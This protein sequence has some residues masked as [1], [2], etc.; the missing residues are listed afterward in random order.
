MQAFHKWQERHLVRRAA[1]FLS[2]GD[3]KIAS[4]TLVRCALRVNDLPLAEQTLKLL[5]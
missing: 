1:G 4:L 2:G 3:Y 5:G